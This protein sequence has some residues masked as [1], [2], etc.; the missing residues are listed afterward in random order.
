[1]SKTPPKR[2]MEVK[3]NDNNS[4]DIIDGLLQ[5]ITLITPCLRDYNLNRMR[6]RN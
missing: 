6:E 3:N 2:S 4:E 5:M 1:M